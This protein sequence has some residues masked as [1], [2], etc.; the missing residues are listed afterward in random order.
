M[1]HLVRI[2][3]LESLMK[4]NVPSKNICQRRIYQTQVIYVGMQRIFNAPHCHPAEL[5]DEYHN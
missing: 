4:P 5:S 1:V 3:V 2:I